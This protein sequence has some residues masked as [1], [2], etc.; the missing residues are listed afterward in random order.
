[1]V[2]KSLLAFRRELSVSLGA[3]SPQAYLYSQRRKA[4]AEK[5]KAV[6]AV[7]GV[8]NARVG[9]TKEEQEWL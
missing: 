8:P 7:S 2:Q 9:L 6:L 1:M 5:P 3:K 4:Q